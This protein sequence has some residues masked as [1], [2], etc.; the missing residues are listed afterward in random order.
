VVV[1]FGELLVMV[2][3]TFLHFAIECSTSV[4]GLVLKSASAP[5]NTK[6]HHDLVEMRNHNPT[7]F[8]RVLSAALTRILY[9]RL[10]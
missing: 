1:S 10:Q 7:I 9:S 8:V 4:H 6:Q 3:T 2:N 5:Q